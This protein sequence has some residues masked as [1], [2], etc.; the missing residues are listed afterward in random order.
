[1]EVGRPGSEAQTVTVW[2]ALANK[3][4]RPPQSSVTKSVHIAVASLQEA[5]LLVVARV[6]VVDVVMHAGGKRPCTTATVTVQCYTH[7]GLCMRTWDRVRIARMPTAIGCSLSLSDRTRAAAFQSS[8]CRQ[9][10]QHDDA[11][12]IQCRLGLQL[13]SYMRNYVTLRRVS[14]TVEMHA[15]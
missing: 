14:K 8:C 1:M 5:T 13:R 6:G 4:H 12:E 7:Q 11:V 3:M 9:Y 15:A 2:R 10:L